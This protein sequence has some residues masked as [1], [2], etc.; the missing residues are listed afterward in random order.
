M[1]PV[2]YER[3]KSTGIRQLYS[4]TKGVGKGMTNDPLEVA[5]IQYML[6]TAFKGQP[7]LH[8]DGV[9]GPKTHQRIIAFQRM[10]LA[11]HYAVDVDG[12]IGPVQHDWVYGKDAAGR[13]RLRTLVALN[14]LYHKADPVASENKEPYHLP[15]RFEILCP[16]KAKKSA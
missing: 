7:E 4:V 1:F 2:I 12:R 3:Y 13:P 8:L 10:A 9:F 16:E 14:I 15:K 11:G 6:N 5:M